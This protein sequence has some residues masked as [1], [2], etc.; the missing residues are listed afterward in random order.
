M[1]FLLKLKEIRKKNNMTQQEIAKLL[2]ISRQSLSQIENERYVI[3]VNMLSKI[4]DIL[5]CTTDELLGR[6]ENNKDILDKNWNTIDRI[7]N[8][9][10]QD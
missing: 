6:D 4:A 7:V 9:K 3:N 5:N 2:N 10:S 1:N 8:K